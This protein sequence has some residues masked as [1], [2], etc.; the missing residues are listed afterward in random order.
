VKPDSVQPPLAM[1]IGAFTQ[2]T[3]RVRVTWTLEESPSEQM[4]CDGMAVAS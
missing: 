3:R 4:A 1:S 2:G